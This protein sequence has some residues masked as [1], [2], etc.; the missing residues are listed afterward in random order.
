MSNNEYPE[1]HQAADSPASD[2]T[3]NSIDGEFQ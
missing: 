1:G 2:V 3:T